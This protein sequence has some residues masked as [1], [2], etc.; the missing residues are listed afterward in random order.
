MQCN[1]INN[2]W[3]ILV[4][5]LAA[6]VCYC[7]SCDW[8]TFNLTYHIFIKKIFSFEFFFDLSFHIDP[9]WLRL[10]LFCPSFNEWIC[11]FDLVIYANVVHCSQ[12]YLIHGSPY[13]CSYRVFYYF[14]VSVA[15]CCLRW[16]QMKNNNEIE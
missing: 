2:V 5:L 6:T 10:L 15:C 16:E 14:M 13:L 1:L 7:C 9:C 11:A 12:G 4:A 8:L 3:V